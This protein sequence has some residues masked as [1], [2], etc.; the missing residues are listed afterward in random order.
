MRKA[1]HPVPGK[2]LIGGLDEQRMQEMLEM[3][4]RQGRQ[5]MGG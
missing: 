5:G 3:Q 4:G 1:P 2:T